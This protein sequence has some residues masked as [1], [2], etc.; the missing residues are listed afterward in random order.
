[1]YK[2]WLKIISIIVFA[3]FFVMLFYL[4]WNID[5][6]PLPYTRINTFTI[7][8]G[9][10]ANDKL[11]DD[12]YSDVP[13]T[14]QAVSSAD[15]IHTEEVVFDPRRWSDQPNGVVTV[16][17]TV[18]SAINQSERRNAIRSTWLSES[19]IN[20]PD[21]SVQYWFIIGAKNVR[22]SDNELIKL[23]Q[24]KFHDL[25]ILHNVDNGYHDLP[26]RTLHSLTYLSTHYHYTYLLKTD[27]DMFIN[28]PTV[29]QELKTIR[30]DTRLYWGRFACQNPPMEDG[31]W[32]EGRWH[33]CDVYYPYAY[34][35]M[36]VLT[37]DVVTLITDNAR[38]LQLY[39]CEDVSLGTWLGS[40]NL[41]RINDVRIFVEHDLRCSRGFIAIHIPSRHVPK[42][43]H[44]IYESLKRKGVVCTKLLRED[45]VPWN[46][47]SANCKS[48]SLMV[49]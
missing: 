43:I 41:H 19:M 26:Y 24:N 12:K 36:Y 8:K 3:T 5:D 45:L 1:M 28:T 48:D 39:S 2:K 11:T 47:F 35:G 40:Y 23:E 14:T 38:L 31:R 13:S 30:P 17:V 33:W 10:L 18:H 29:L 49:V 27:D 42:V 4:L 15:D 32:K 20:I 25:L 37:H 21:I 34:G 44:Q 22:Q 16:L 6:Q 9:D 7:D 46:E